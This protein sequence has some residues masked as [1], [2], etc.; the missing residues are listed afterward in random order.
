[1]ENHNAF[2]RHSVAL[3]SLLYRHFPGRPDIDTSQSKDGALLSDTVEFWSKSGLIAIGQTAET[4]G[5]KPYYF[6]VGLTRLGLTVL[7]SHFNDPSQAKT[8]GERIVDLDSS[9]AS[10]RLEDVKHVISELLKY[11]T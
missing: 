11:L 8:L 3:L 6:S 2:D 7:R 1:M 4:F 9:P 10:D 5:S